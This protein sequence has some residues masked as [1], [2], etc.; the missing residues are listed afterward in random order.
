MTDLPT[1][2]HGL[3][4]PLVT[5][6]RNN[7]LDETSLRRLT[8]HYAGEAVDGF[9]LGAT[10]G[11]GMTLR[12][13]ELEHLVAIVRDEMAAGRRN[14]PIC[15]G[16]SGADTSRLKD[17]LDETADWPIDGY[18]IASPYYVRPSQRGL[19]AHFEALADHAAW[20]LAL[21]N[22]PY[23]CAVNITNQ[24]MLRL[25]EHPNIMGLK[26]CGA[27]REQ[28]IA[29]LRDRPKGFRVLTGEDAKYL[30]ALSDG[31]DGGIL[32]S[33]HIETA[34]FAAVY[35]EIKRG[36]HD[37]ARARWQEVAELTRLLFAEP[38]PAPAKYWLW[39]TGL[40]D[41]PEVRLPMVEV[42]SE[43]AAQLD[44]EIERR[45]QVAA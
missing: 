12:D 6:F 45:M 25:L 23:R 17:R 16:L 22:I 24:T 14:L 20:P 32:L 8:R 11:E 9:I 44:R 41:S 28:S 40:I 3:W 42:S 30:E 33:A 29:L 15:L 10:S 43:L 35:A 31:A 1:H 2:L 26:D 19:L 4:L 38:S 21:Y 18:L 39:R 27:S 34:T 37:A 7:R 13:A 5:P 36:N